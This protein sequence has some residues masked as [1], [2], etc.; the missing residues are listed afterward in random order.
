MLDKRV[1]HQGVS[2]DRRMHTIEWYDE[3]CDDRDVRGCDVRRSVLVS[4]CCIESVQRGGE[5]NR[6]AKGESGCCVGR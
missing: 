5:M 3:G 4:Y 1:A 6:A 2:S